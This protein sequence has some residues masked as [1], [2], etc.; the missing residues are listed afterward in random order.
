MFCY[1]CDTGGGEAV[2]V[3]WPAVWRM[4]GGTLWWQVCPILLRQCHLPAVLL[5]VL[6]GKHPLPRRPRVP[7]AAGQRGSRPSPAD[8]LPLELKTGTPGEPGTAACKTTQKQHVCC[9]KKR[10][11]VW[12]LNPSCQY[13]VH[14][15]IQYIEN[16]YDYKYIN[17]SLSFVA[18]RNTTSLSLFHQTTSFSSLPVH[19]RLG[20]EFLW[21]VRVF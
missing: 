10:C 2:R 16:I 21:Y 4:S 7:Q 14:N 11:L 20:T 18:V 9:V 1:S 12:P 8:P 6:L 17:I 13:R 5:R 19:L 15:R 3:G